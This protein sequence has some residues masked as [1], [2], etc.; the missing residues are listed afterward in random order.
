M[1]EALMKRFLNVYCLK[2]DGFAG[3][4][5]LW[6]VSMRMHGDAPSSDQHFWKERIKLEF[7][8]GDGNSQT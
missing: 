5:S 8:R 1:G 4:S 2:L 7:K 3:F 6:G